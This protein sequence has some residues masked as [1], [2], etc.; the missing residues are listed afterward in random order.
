MYAKE[1]YNKNKEKYI[2][3]NILYNGKIRDEV[4]PV[5]EA[6]KSKPCPDCERSY[7]P[8]VMDFDHL[9][10]ELKYMSVSQMVGRGHKL[11]NILT[12]IDKCEL[13]CSNCHRIRTY[14]RR[15]GLM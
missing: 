14:K 13:I 4:L 3:R 11:E 8:Y 1:H 7:P 5:I 2:Q 12:E 15:M 10:P 9:D 6:L